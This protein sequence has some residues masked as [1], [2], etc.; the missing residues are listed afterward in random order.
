MKII[1]CDSCGTQLRE[2]YFRA[3]AEVRSAVLERY[4][5]RVFITV[6][7]DDDEQHFDACSW[8]CVAELAAKRSADRASSQIEEGEQP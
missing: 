1:Q 7:H 5:D 6:E 3:P 8:S 2:P 4:P